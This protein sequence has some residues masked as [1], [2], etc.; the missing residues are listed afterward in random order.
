MRKRQTSLDADM[1]EVR[2]IYMMVSNPRHRQQ[3]TLLLETAACLFAALEENSSRE[4]E[5]R[6]WHTKKKPH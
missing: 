3:L 5:Q 1:E 2:N 4:G 6:K